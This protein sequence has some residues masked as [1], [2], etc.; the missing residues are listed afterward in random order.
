MQKGVFHK[1]PIPAARAEQ[2][3]SEGVEGGAGSVP[4]E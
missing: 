1:E 2:A 4:E 3:P